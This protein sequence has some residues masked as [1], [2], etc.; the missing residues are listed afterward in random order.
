VSE[1]KG[2]SAVVTLSPQGT[3]IIEAPNQ[4]ALSQG[5]ASATL[6]V[7]VVGHG[8]FRQSVPGRSDQEAVVPLSGASATSSTLI[9][10]DTNFVTAVAIVNRSSL[11]NAVTVV[12][13]D[14]TGANLG[15]S[16]VNLPPNGNVAVL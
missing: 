5:Y 10:D 9:W 13:R 14:P 3:A 8:I 16:T 7:G 12:V 4:G 2:E 15:N 11:P 6:P 1:T